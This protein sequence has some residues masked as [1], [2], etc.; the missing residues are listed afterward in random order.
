MQG[1]SGISDSMYPITLFCDDEPQ[2]FYLTDEAI[3]TLF[4]VL[5]EIR[6]A[7]QPLQL[8]PAVSPHAE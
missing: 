2:T 1:M 4:L 8:A 6:R 7:R 3:E 5:L